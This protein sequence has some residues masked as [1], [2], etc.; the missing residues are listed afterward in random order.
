MLKKLIDKRNL[1]LIIFLSILISL[2]I[3]SLIFCDRSDMVEIFVLTPLVTFL[4][5]FFLR[6]AFKIIGMHATTKV[7]KIYAY[8]FIF[9]GFLG[10][11]VSIIGFLKGFPND[12]SSTIGTCFSI[13]IGAID[14]AKK[15]FTTET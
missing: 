9:A 7:L 8:F 12:F 1:L 15:V 10:S 14:S 2:W 3:L 13:V 5:Y 4:F 11:I 6:F